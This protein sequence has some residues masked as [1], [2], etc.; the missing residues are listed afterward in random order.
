MQLTQ[1]ETDLL[2]DLK[3]QEK[4]CVEKYKK[5]AEQAKDEQLQRLFLKITEI[6]QQHYEA[7]SAIMNNS[8]PPASIPTPVD[9]GF[10]ATY[11][12]DEN[13]QKKND[14][15]L[16]NDMLAM[17]KHASHMYDTSVFEFKEQALRNQ[18]NSIQKQEQEH[19]KLIYDYMSVN[20]MYS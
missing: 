17:E 19:G 2:K 1:K 11:G 9:N 7:V 10:V 8:T 5:A 15:Y 13:E 20:S 14:C 18:L 3:G 16:C 4:L 6:E 12:M